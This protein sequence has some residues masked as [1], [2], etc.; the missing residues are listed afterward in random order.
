M[1]ADDAERVLERD[2][3]LVGDHALELLAGGRAA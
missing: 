3:S 2:A 1:L